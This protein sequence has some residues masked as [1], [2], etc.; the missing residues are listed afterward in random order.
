MKTIE[1]GAYKIEFRLPSII[2]AM[3][4]LG[5]SGINLTD[6]KE[7]EKK[8]LSFMADLMEQ[9]ERFITK[10]E[11]SGKP[12]KWEDSIHDRAFSAPL[13]MLAMQIMESFSDTETEDRKKP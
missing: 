2:E 8:Q 7:V 5:N 1:N 12:V 3:R 6:P 11:K 9:S 13:S 4:M 10:I